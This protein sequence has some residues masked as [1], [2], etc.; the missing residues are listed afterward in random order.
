MKTIGDACISVI[1]TADAVDKAAQALAVGKLWFDGGLKLGFKTPPDRPNRPR[2]PV[3]LPPRDMPKRRGAGTG[4]NKNALLHAVAHIELNAIDL[5]FDIVARF[6]SSFEGQTQIDFINDWIEVGMDESRHYT[7]VTKRL[8]ELGCNYGDLPA[9][10]GLWE[11]AQKTA[12]DLLARLAI[13]PMVLEARGL[14]VTPNMITRF[15]SFGDSQSADIL[16]VIYEEEISHVA[17]GNKWFN[18]LCDISNIEKVDTFQSLVNKHF[19]GGLIR[20]FNYEAREKA[21]LIQ[22]YYEPLA[23]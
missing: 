9:H 7:M 14:D 16:Q 21:G 11:A 4:A 8:G 18:H 6:A 1:T 23:Q 15:N 17:K 19:S 13:V 2:A 20:P 22:D 10:D 5:A 3:L 12:H